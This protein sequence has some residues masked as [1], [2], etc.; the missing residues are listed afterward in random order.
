MQRCTRKFHPGLTEQQGRVVKVEG[1]AKDQ[2]RMKDK[3]RVQAE[4]KDT[5]SEGK[6]AESG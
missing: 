3:I 1:K 4:S 6:D 2:G 5:Y